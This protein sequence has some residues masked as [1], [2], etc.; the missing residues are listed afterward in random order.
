MKKNGFTLSE[1]IISLSVI[2]IASALMMPAITKLMPDKYKTK[3]VNVHSKIVSAVNTLLDDDAIY[4]CVDNDS[5]EGLSCDGQAQKTDLRNDNRYR[6][7]NKFENLMVYQLG[8]ENARNPID[9]YRWMTPDGAYWRFE[10]GCDND[11][12]G[13]F[14]ANANGTCTTNNALC[15]RITVDLNG[16]VANSRPNR[17]FGQNGE[18]KPDR[19]R[20][21]VDN[22]GGV[23]PDDAMS[24]AYLR[25]SFKSADKKDDRA[26][27]RQLYADKARYRD[28]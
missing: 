2:G 22:Y 12:N 5:K 15:Y 1:L 3:T 20:F 4:W 13:T 19:F 25:N 18:Q 16:A 10:R 17:I 23:T 28:L 14:T 7:A 11:G 9:N 24:A 6:G 8:L 21:R 26:R 27:A